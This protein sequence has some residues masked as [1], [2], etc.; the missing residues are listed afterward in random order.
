METKCANFEISR[1]ARLLKVSRSGYYKWLQS[2]RAVPPSKVRRR[3]LEVKILSFHHDSHGIYGAPRITADL[4]E[5]GDSVCQNTVAKYMRNLKVAGVSP[6]LFKTTTISDPTKSYLPDLIKRQF[7]QDELDALWPS[8]ITYLKIGSRDVYLC[9]VRDECSSKV[10]GLEL[11]DNIKTEITTKAL[12]QLL[13][14]EMDVLK[15]PYSTQIKK[16]SSMTRK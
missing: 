9:A 12:E 2:K 8:D 7:I 10:L 5:N 16:A 4:V 11:D 15:E 13:Q 14:K 6:R 1:M 3:E